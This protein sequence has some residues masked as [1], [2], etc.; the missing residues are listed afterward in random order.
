MGSEKFS[1][2][3]KSGYNKGTIRSDIRYLVVSIDAR[4]HRLISISYVSCHGRRSRVRVSSS[5]PLFLYL[6]KS[7]FHRGNTK[8]QLLDLC[9][10]WHRSNQL[11]K[12]PLRRT[13][14]W[15]Q[16]LGVHIHRN[17]ATRVSHQLLGGFHV[18]TTSLQQCCKRAAEGMPA[19]DLGD[20]GTLGCGPNVPPQQVLRPVRLHAM[21]VGACKY[22]VVKLVAKITS[23]RHAV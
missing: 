18:L 14:R 5:P 8:E 6:R 17:P 20:P 3:T 1:N 22:P 2:S 11:C 13:L 19:D 7:S 23:E 9:F 15:R 16:S 21:H 4:R 12:L 10:L